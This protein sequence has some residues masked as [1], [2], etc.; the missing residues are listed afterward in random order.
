MDGYVFPGR[1][2]NVQQVHEMRLNI[3]ISQGN[4]N[5][6]LTEITLTSTRMAIFIK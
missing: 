4:A 3:T 5:Q 6:S 1:Y 2:T